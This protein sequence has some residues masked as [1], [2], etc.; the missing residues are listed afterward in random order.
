MEGRTITILAGANKERLILHEKAFAI[1]GSPS[2]ETLVHGS[3]KEA[4]TCVIGWSH[5]EAATVKRF[6]TYLY[7][8]DYNA[9]WPTRRPKQSNGDPIQTIFPSQVRSQA[10]KEEPGLEVPQAE[11]TGVDG[12]VA[13]P[14]AEEAPAEEVPVVADPE[15]P[16]AVAIEEPEAAS[17]QGNNIPDAAFQQ[18]LLDSINTRPL[19][20]INRC[21][22]MEQ[23]DQ[24]QRTA[25]GIFDKLDYPYRRY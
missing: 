13:E 4:S 20:P 14:A 6:L 17:E 1:S 11:A 25:A 21:V 16:D 8:G 3:F 22:Q 5:T 23:R 24:V 10:A 12:L 18:A 15:M 19:T 7:V 9:P 2:L